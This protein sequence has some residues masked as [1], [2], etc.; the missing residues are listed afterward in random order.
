[1]EGQ[2]YRG[3]VHGGVIA[4]LL[5]ET[6]GWAPSLESNRMYVTGE[7]TTRFIQPFPIGKE[8]IIEARAEKVTSR[9]AL[10]AGEVR[11]GAGTLY[12]SAT[13]KYLPMSEAPTREVDA[14]LIY[15]PDTLALFAP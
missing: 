12:A 13:G 4:T 1:M 11:D 2:G 8:M 7:L 6:M 14:Q 9:M 15:G 5:D 10:V 3:V